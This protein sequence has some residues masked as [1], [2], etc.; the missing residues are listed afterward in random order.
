MAD[1]FLWLQRE[2]LYWARR[3]GVPITESLPAGFPAST[4]DAQAVLAEIG[5]EDPGLLAR[6]T[7][8]LFELFW[9]QG[10]SDVVK[11]NRISSVL[12]ELLGQETDRIKNI[13]QEV[14]SSQWIDDSW[15]AC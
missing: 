1:K 6:V 4:G 2:R 5:S 13:L 11:P 15:H 9:A 12:D 3:F 14:R 7:D 8:R 10:D